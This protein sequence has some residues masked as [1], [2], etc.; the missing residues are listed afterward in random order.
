MK[1]IAG[2]LAVR[3]LALGSLSLF[4]VRA[5]AR[6]AL[7]IPK[8]IGAT[9]G[10]FRSPL[11]VAAGDAGAILAGDYVRRVAALHHGFER[12]VMLG[13]FWA[14]RRSSWPSNGSGR[15]LTRMVFR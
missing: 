4:R 7:L 10:P 12:G 8:V 2:L 9:L 5:P 6:A 11:V 3:S 1:A 15:A 14:R 13:R